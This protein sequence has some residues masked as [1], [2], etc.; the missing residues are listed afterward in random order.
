[1]SF[2]SI[3]KHGFIKKKKYIKGMR[4]DNISGL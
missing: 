2:S 3:H 4:Y 1:M